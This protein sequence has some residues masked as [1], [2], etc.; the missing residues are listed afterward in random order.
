LEWNAPPQFIRQATGHDPYDDPERAWLS[1]VEIFDIDAT[2]RSGVSAPATQDATV[3]HDGHH[4]YTQWGIGETSWLV[5]PLYKTPDE[6]LAFDPRT[7]D[8]SSFQ[9]KVDRYCQQYEAVQDWYG[10]RT[11]WIPGQYQ[12]VTHYMT[13]WCDWQVF[14]EL[15]ALEPERCRP[16][17]DRCESYSVEV[18]EAW[19]HSSAPAVVAH[20]DLCGSRGPIYS[21]D[22]LR[23]DVF[24][25][26][27]RIYEPLKR[28]N[29]K[30]IATSDGFIEPI[31][32]DLLSAGADGLFIEPMNDIGRMADLVGP[33]G[34]LWGGGSSVVVTTATPEDIRG[35]IRR[36]MEQARR[37]PSFLFGLGGEALQNVPVENYRAYLA[38]CSEYGER[39]G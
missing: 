38:A 34:I 33:R 4:A 32:K 19:A 14:L 17:F 6:I 9:E 25:R 15:L 29:I 35:D 31:A 39:P 37:L 8:Q 26:Y 10:D 27:K 28:R 16:L 36:R 7:H 3:R 13:K 23:R 1:F 18:M 11:L 5:D 21:P 20:E 2:L 30:V 22:F 24:P 12:L